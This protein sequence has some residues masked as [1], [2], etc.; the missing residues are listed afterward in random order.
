MYIYCLPHDNINK[1]WTHQT[2]RSNCLVD[3]GYQVQSLHHVRRI[4]PSHPHVL[5]I[6]SHHTRHHHAGLAWCHSLSRH[7]SLLHHLRVH[8]H[9]R[10]IHGMIHRTHLLHHGSILGGTSDLSSSHHRS[11]S[12]KHLL[13]MSHEQ[14]H[15]LLLLHLKKAGLPSHHRHTAGAGIEVGLLLLLLT[16]HLGSRSRRG[17]LIR[18]TECLDSDPAG[19]LTAHLH[20]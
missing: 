6:H 17:R 14:L 11:F 20:A 3:A 8:S 15:V 1:I 19:S 5:R 7:T 18:P 9:V 12:L 16:G 4:I 2:P 13:T 10:M